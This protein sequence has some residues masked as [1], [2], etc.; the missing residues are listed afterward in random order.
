MT[1]A[2]L[3]LGF[4]VWE[5][6]VIYAW[7]DW[8][9]SLCGLIV[10]TAFLTHPDMPRTILDIQGL[11]LWNVLFFIVLLAWMVQRRHEGLRWDVPR[12]AGVLLW[13]GLGVVVCGFVR[14]LGDRQSLVEDLTLARLVSEYLINPVK[15]VA[16]GLLLFD[17]SRNRRRLA[18]GL[19]A[20]LSLYLLVGFQVIRVLLR[21]VPADG[22]SLFDYAPDEV[23]TSVGLHR[24]DV[25]VMLAGA[26][27]ALLAMRAFV[28]SVSYRM[29]I[30]LG[31]VVVLLAQ[32]L[33][34]GRGGYLAW[35]AVGLTL[36][37]VRWRRY[38]L[39]APLSVVLLLAL[40]PGVA[41]RALHGLSG[42]TES[43][44]Q[45]VDLD[46]VTS[47][48]TV[49]WPLVSAKILEAPFIGYGVAAMQRTGLS[50]TLRADDLIGSL[51][52][53]P[54]NAYLEML[55]DSGL[56][57][58]LVTLALYGT[59]VAAGLSLVR[60][61]GSPEHVAV[62]AMG[63]SLVLAQMVGSLTGQSFWPREATFGMW[64]AVGL[65]L[66]VWG[67]RSRVSPD[68]LEQESGG[69]GTGSTDMSLWPPAGIRSVADAA[70]WRRDRESLRGTARRETP[71]T[72]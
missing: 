9:K 60:D 13:L 65:L 72:S 67:Q 5:V 31:S 27:W 57:G 30:V 28:T 32:V 6:S 11:N 10:F 64:C 20:I 47:G 2:L 16:V 15:Y 61:P 3:A 68:S 48:R 50:A 42:A 26:F 59:F 4:V 35:C 38:L 63:L 18:L 25:S 12:F 52:Q 22:G 62:G 21:V 46:V 70:W 19:A 1:Q 45:E 71:S 56:V 55:L 37:L 41:D 43:A 8:Y 14:L 54:H 39:L 7:R 23:M 34:G 49:I 33:T 51:I 36:G 66:R 24:N 40:A 44:S 58:L 69:R 29:A 17:G 53:H